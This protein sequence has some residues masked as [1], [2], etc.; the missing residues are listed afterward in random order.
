MASFFRVRESGGT[1]CHD[2]RRAAERRLEAI[3]RQITELVATRHQM[4]QTLRGWDRMLARAGD[5][6]RA[7]LLET[8]SAIDRPPGDRRGRLRNRRI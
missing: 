5:G 1:P 4:R 8:L 6:Q 7:Y 2:V 3:D